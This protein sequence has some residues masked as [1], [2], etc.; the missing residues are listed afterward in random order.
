MKTSRQCKLCLIFT[1]QIK[2]Q[3]EVLIQRKRVAKEHW[4]FKRSLA[5]SGDQKNFTT[6]RWK[7]GI[8]AS[9]QFW[10]LDLAGLKWSMCCWWWKAPI[11][12][13]N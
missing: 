4:K 6:R 10:L 1:Q 2:I 11:I 3:P 5:L 12:L 8:S 13:I 7:L 9:K